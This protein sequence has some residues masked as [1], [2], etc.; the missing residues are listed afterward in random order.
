MHPRALRHREGVPRALS[1][2]LSNV[3]VHNLSLDATSPFQPQ[4]PP[5]SRRHQRSSKR[6]PGNVCVCVMGGGWGGGG[7]PRRQ[8]PHRGSFLILWR[9]LLTQMRTVRRR[10][11]PGRHSPPKLQASVALS[12]DLSHCAGPQP[13]LL[14][15][16]TPA[17]CPPAHHHRPL[18]SQFRLRRSPCLHWAPSPNYLRDFCLCLNPRSRA[19]RDAQGLLTRWTCVQPPA[20][21]HRSP[22]S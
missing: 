14:L 5:K 6:P 11:W 18:T 4:Q 15:F 10:A 7:A 2:S 21:P 3:E 9:S 16:A 12:R 13:R 19:P 20:L 17:T 22:A 1:L 8:G